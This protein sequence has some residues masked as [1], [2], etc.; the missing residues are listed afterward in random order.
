MNKSRYILVILF[1]LIIY[2]INKV[3][4]LYLYRNGVDT[5]LTIKNN[6]LYPSVHCH[7]IDRENL[8]N[9]LYHS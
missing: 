9:S 2:I 8:K 7:M 6:I 5:F 1:I 3:L 4:I